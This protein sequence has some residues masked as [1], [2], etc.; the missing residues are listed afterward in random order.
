LRELAAEALGM[1]VRIGRPDLSGF[2]HG[3]AGPAYASASGALRVRLDEPTLDDVEEH[4]Q[5]TLAHLAAAMR[6]GVS[7]AWR[8][9]REN[10]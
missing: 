10:F 8:W 1:P 3:E 5:P 4:F 9:L 2:D 7:G 6:D